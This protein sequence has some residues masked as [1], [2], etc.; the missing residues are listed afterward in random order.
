MPAGT[1]TAL[2]AQAHDQQRVNIFVDGRFALGVSIGTLAK[3]G[4]YVGK[5][6]DE[7]AY[8]RLEQAERADQAV[9]AALRFLDARPRSSAEIHERLR[10]KGFAPEFITA[11]IERL[12]QLGLVDDAAFAR[13][14]IENRLAC[15]PRGVGA[16]RD[17]LRRKGIERDVV[18]EALA[19]GAL[20]EDDA[21][22]ALVLARAVVG[23]YAG[24]PDQAA[25]TRRLGG[26]LQRRGF[27]F[28]V[29]YPIVEQ[30]W[31][32]LAHARDDR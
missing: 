22:R 1:I 6:L 4:L 24:A 32:E 18:E 21:A 7:A 20:A 11:A 25:F 23:K 2:Q 9:Q 5:Q 10:R 13:F 12:E 28:D 17:E 27:G 19:E 8:A 29:I 15:R 30:L 26:Y 14:W 16:L 31:Q 3:E